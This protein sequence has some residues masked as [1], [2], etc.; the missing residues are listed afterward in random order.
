V[1]AIGDAGGIMTSDDLKS[2]RATVRAPVRG[3]YR[4]YDII[5]MPQPSSGGVVLLE[6]LNILEGFPMH[7]MKQGSAPSLHVMIEA[8]KRAY[9]DRARYLGDPDF[10]KAPVATLTSKDYAAKQRASID[11]DHAT[12]W[13]MR[14]RRHRRMKA[15]TP[16]IFRWWIILAMRSATPIR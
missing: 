3:S 11:L 10:V 6:T 2:Y 13:T 16:R 15:A 7:D 14:S 1:K 9:A 12:P 8:M 5:S 4:G